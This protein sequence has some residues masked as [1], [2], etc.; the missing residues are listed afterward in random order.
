M[1]QN[2]LNVCHRGGER[3]RGREGEREKGTEGQ[4]DRGI[5]EKARGG[6]DCGGI[7]TEWSKME[8]EEG[9]GE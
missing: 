3:A 1:D 4:R 5:G 2:K 7:K 8:R 9:E 6:G